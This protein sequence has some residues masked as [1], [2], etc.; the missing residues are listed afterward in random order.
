MTAIERIFR[1]FEQYGSLHY[2]EDATQLQHALQTAELA[3]REG[4]SDA[5]IAAALLHD[6]GQLLDDA[7]SAAERLGIDARHEISGATFLK[8]FFPPA[9][10]E[11]VR[12][13]VAAKRY[14]CAVEPSYATGLSN[15]SALSL[16]L[17]GGPMSAKQVREFEAEPFLEDAIALRRFD[18]T[19][20]DP[21]RR[22]PELESYRALLRALMT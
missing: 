17:Q 1:L 19:G 22:S 6:I 15:A 12:L 4:H 3:R 7:G 2:G 5:L 20:K 21:T 18:D 10:Y 8:Q 11:P 13:H 9:V 16:A 14:L